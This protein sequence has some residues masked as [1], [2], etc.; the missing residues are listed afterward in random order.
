MWSY[1][2]HINSN[3]SFADHLKLGRWIVKYLHDCEGDREDQIWMPL[4]E[5]VFFELSKVD[6]G[7]NIILWESGINHF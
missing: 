6:G 1:N 7:P 2:N 3:K 4:D 5:R